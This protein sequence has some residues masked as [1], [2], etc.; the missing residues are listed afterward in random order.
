M[1]LT[2]HLTEVDRIL[3]RTLQLQNHGRPRGI[4]CPS[5][6]QQRRPPHPSCRSGSSNKIAEEGE[7]SR[8]VQY[9]RRA[10]TGGGGDDQ[11]FTDHLQ[12]DL[13]DGEVAYI[14]DAVPHHHPPKE[15]QL[16]AMPELQNY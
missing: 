1:C 10:G 12:Q 11:C 13:A 15:R 16:T 14:L 4:E 9:P 2:R 3:L 7:V 6:N 8:N 5:S